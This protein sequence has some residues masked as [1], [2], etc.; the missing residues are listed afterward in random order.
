M[1]LSSTF[2]ERLYQMEETRNRR[3]SLLQAEK[4][5]QQNKSQILAS[6]LSDIRYIEQRCLKLDHKIASQQFIISSLKSQLDRLGSIYL[7]Q[8]QQFRVLKSE[9]ENLEELDKEKD[10]YF[11]LKAREIDEFRARAEIFATE[12][13]WCAE[14][15]RNCV[16]ELNSSFLQ[17]QHSTGYSNN[18]D[19][20]AA[21]LRKS[22]LQATKE[23]LDRRLASNYNT[24]A[25]LQKQLKSLLISQKECR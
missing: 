12:C 15:L 9:T 7:D 13:Q 24:R 3:L 25:Q 6:K 18:S 16:N 8:I 4:E 5:L 10:K 17:L 14:E 1:A 19:L 21:E 2:E 20:T 11:A 22:E 23:N